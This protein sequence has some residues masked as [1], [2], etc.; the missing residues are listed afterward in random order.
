MISWWQ[1][2][3]GVGPAGIAGRHAAF[4]EVT[5]WLEPWRDLG[6]GNYLGTDSGKGAAGGAE[7]AFGEEMP[8]K[9]VK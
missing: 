2:D 5:A 1:K 7:P 6:D 4:P 8:G 3:D 9:A